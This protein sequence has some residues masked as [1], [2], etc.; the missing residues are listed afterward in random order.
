MAA[1]L[2]LLTCVLLAAQPADRTEYLAMPRLNRGQELV[3][4]GTYTEES[5][6]QGVEFSRS[7]RLETR[8]LVLDRNINTYQIA[9]YTVLRAAL[10]HQQDDEVATA[11]VRLELAHLGARGQVTADPS[12]L[13][14]V[15]L[16]GPAT[17]ECG[18]FVSV[19]R[20]WLRLNETWETLE[21]DRPAR[22][23]KV[24]AVDMIHN[25]SCLRLEALEKSS[26]WDHPRADHI[27]WRRR[28]TVWLAP[29]FGAAYKVQRT[30]ERREPARRRPSERA[31]V[32]YE[33]QSDMTYP[34]QLFEDRR[35]EVLE[36]V[37]FRQ[38]IAAYLP[39][40]TRYGTIPF[41]AMLAKIG[42]YLDNHP[43]TPYREAVLQVKRQVE[44]AR[45]G[46]SP[47]QVAPVASNSTASPVAVIDRQAPDFAATDLFS[48]TT[49]RLRSWSG[50]PV[51]LLFYTPESQG[52]ET[53]LRFAQGIHQA[54]PKVTVVGLAMS[55]SSDK[56]LKQR[57]ELKLTFRLLS[58][59][60]LRQGYRVDATPKLVLID[61]DGTV[62]SQLEGWGPET[63]AAIEEEL[64]HCLQGKAEFAPAR[65]FAGDSRHP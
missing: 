37:H 35:E 2:C 62:R 29:R 42:Y 61:G 15:P 54:Y 41:D 43:R 24:A 39:D 38:S 25:T 52:A 23:W 16:E 19:P 51:L 65:P 12:G 1:N 59:L 17:V 60:G 9:F 4:R 58:G 32:D 50:H 36:A 55:A 8:V 26:D 45:R 28:D 34:G 20:D 7:Y 31:V 13:L 47:P 57:S 40:P 53:E 48:G 30:I 6:G 11:S 21:A 44:A 27:A 3:Y 46:E 22:V 33:L 5:R 56:V 64:K 18:Q 49:V 10:P 63:P 14:A